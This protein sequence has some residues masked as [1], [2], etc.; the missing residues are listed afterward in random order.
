MLFRSLVM[1]IAGSFNSV[2]QVQSTDA[3]AFTS[4][5]E[6]ILPS[7]Y[8]EW[9][10]VGT[11]LGMTYG[12]A[13]RAE[14]AP[15]VFDNIY[16]TRDAYRAF[17]R[18]GKWPDRT[19]FIMEGRASES[20]ELLA[21]TGQAQGEARFLEA[22]VKDPSRFPDTIWGYFNFGGAKAPRASARQIPKSFDCYTCHAQNTAVEN[23]FVQFYPALFEVA[24]KLGTVKTT[25]DPARKF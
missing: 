15:L 22:A 9:V 5:G 20:H 12:P 1:T 21:N 2:A 10:F 8:R 23:T 7:D 14:G 24:R 16:V 25:Y 17:M 19:M 4:A 18:S 11:G 13:K 3:P 6:L